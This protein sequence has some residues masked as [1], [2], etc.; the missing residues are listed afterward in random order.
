MSPEKDIAEGADVPPE[1]PEKPAP[2]PAPVEPAA[3][4][5]KAR[6][7]PKRSKNK[8][9]VLAVSVEEEPPEPEPPIPEPPKLKRQARPEAAPKAAPRVEEA[10]PPQR[11]KRWLPTCSRLCDSN[12]M[13]A[14]TAVEIS[15]QLGFLDHI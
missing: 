5:P 15:T 10:P 12:N 9:K 3:P 1:E 4:T 11:R 8:P 13:I 2:D 14:Q 6:G 7:R